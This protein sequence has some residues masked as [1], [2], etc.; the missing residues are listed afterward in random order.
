MKDMNGTEIKWGDWVRS[1]TIEPQLPN[2]WVGKITATNKG[3]LDEQYMYIRLVGEEQ[4]YRARA[5]HFIK[6]EPEDLAYYMMIAETGG[7]DES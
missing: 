5:Y 3:M 1:P 4:S 7:T 6:I 2:P